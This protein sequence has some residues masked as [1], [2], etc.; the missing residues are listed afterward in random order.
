MDRGEERGEGFSQWKDLPK[1]DSRASLQDGSN[2]GNVT[3]DVIRP[4][5]TGVGPKLGIEGEEAC[6]SP[7]IVYMLAGLGIVLAAWLWSRNRRK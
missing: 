3:V 1:G 7:G 2:L 5:R 6:M 4:R